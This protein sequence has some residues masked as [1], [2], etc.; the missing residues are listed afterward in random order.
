MKKKML[1]LK[2]GKNVKAVAADSQCCKGA[3]SADK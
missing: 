3:P 1:V 2:K